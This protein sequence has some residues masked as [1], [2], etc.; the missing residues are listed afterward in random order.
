[1]GQ[2]FSDTSVASGNVKLHQQIRQTDVLDCQKLSDCRH[3]QRTCQIGLS[4]AGGPQQQNNIDKKLDKMYHS[5]DTLYVNLFDKIIGFGSLIGFFLLIIIA[6]IMLVTQRY[7]TD[8]FV[9]LGILS[10]V[11]AIIIALLP[12]ALW[13][14]EKFRLSFTISNIDD[15]TP[16]SFYAYCRKGTALVLSIAG[17]VILIISIMCFAKT[18]VIKY[19]DEIA[20][21]PDA[22]MYSHTSAYIDAK[23]E[24]WNEIIESGDYAIGVFLTHLE[25]AEQ[26]GLKEQLMMCAIVEINN[27]ES[28]FTWNTKDDFL[29]QY[30]SRPPKIITK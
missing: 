18:P 23:P 29:F 28:D 2:K 26:T 6:I 10:F 27:I 21:N 24:M 13:S 5:D 7:P 22:M 8:N 14:I 1:L 3:S 16:S 19:I 30:Y 15:A 20:S 4:T 17:V 11:L 9:V 25:K 12:K